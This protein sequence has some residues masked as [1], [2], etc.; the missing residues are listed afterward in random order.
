MTD[1]SNNTP[2]FHGR[3]L[4]PTIIAIHAENGTEAWK[5]ELEKVS[6]LCNLPKMSHDGLNLY[7]AIGG[8]GAGLYNIDTVKK[9]VGW[10]YKPRGKGK[11]HGYPALNKAG[12]VAYIRVKVDKKNDELHA[13]D[14]KK[15]K[16]LWKRVPHQS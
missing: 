10:I 7:A 14:T 9:R 16:L 8:D 1:R 11:P 3:S 5:A 12:T 15:G 6:C 4:H 13:V 2:C